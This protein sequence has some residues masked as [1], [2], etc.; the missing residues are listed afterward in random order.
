M[1]QLA[2]IVGPVPCA[3]IRAAEVREAY[4]QQFPHEWVAVEMAVMR[5]LA[6]MQCPLCEGTRKVGPT[7]CRFCNG[8]GQV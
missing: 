7:R 6:E 8:T 4:R 5:A 1:S 3:E 2:T